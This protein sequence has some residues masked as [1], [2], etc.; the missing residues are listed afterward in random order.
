MIVFLGIFIPK[1]LGLRF[2]NYVMILLQH[3]LTWLVLT[4]YAELLV[5]DEANRNVGLLQMFCFIRGSGDVKRRSLKKA[6][7]EIVEQERG[8]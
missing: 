5:L 2:Q 8:D 7:K 1:L 6:A 3:R 4:S